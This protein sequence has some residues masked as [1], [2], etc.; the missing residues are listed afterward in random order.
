MARLISVVIPAYNAEKFIEEAVH[1]ILNQT[2]ANIEILVADN[3]WDKVLA[4]S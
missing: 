3:F 4:Q 2:Y 1:S